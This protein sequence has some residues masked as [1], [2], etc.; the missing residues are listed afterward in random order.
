M[1]PM[2]MKSKPFGQ[3][4]VWLLALVAVVA[5]SATTTFAIINFL[6]AQKR[7]QISTPI[8]R[9]IPVTV[10]AVSAEGGLE[11]QGEIVRLFAPSSPQSPNP[12]IE[13]LLVKRGDRIQS[14]QTIAILDTR[15]RL[16][17][18]LKKAQKQALVAE[19][20]LIKVR[21]GSQKGA[22]NARKASIE[23]IKA[24]RS[25]QITA[26]QATIERLDAELLGEKKAQQATIE[27][28][29]AELNNATLECKR[30]QQLFSE[31]AVPASTRDSKC[32]LQTTAQQQ[33]FESE[34]GLNRIVTSR[35]EQINE[36]KANLK[37]TV[38]TLKQQQAEATANL[39]QTEEVRPEDVSIAEAELE[40]AKAAVL[41]A[42]A[43]LELAYVRSPKSG[44]I[45]NI[46]TRP[47]EIV[48]RDGIV[49]IGQTSQMYVRAEIY[50]T[51]IAKVRVG[52]R[53]TVT[54][55]GFEGKLKGTVEDIGLKIAKKD[56]LGTDPV[57][58]IDARIV[59]VKIRLDREDSQ[60]VASLTNLKVKLVINTDSVKISKP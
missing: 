24:E 26:Q 39:N 21:V 9:D 45:I 1:N 23:S 28:L 2:E 19:A 15:D 6:P 50:E 34:A 52:Q 8:P 27:R 37:R 56:V 35:T 47:G 11:P 44:Q 22:I 20:N 17:A 49:E 25:G 4:G 42:Q 31:G 51:D 60:K 32:L 38:D 36:A 29:K 33:V 18:N 13:K 41:Q 53:A 57:A 12:R 7:E 58:D 16:S 40:N 43:E 46:N 30:Y 55:S 5:A 48:S 14:R 54:S 59:E 10:S 3:K